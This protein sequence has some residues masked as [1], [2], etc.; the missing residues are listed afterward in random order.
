MKNAKIERRKKNVK[1]S[2][3]KCG[4]SLDADVHTNV[5]RPF[6]FHPQKLRATISILFRNVFTTFNAHRSPNADA[7]HRVQ[8]LIEVFHFVAHNYTHTRNE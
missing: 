4:S 2:S 5:Q 6:N 3:S 8:F 7:V 1:T